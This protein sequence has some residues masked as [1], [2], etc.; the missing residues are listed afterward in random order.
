[1]VD[2]TL[3]FCENNFDGLVIDSVIRVE[4]DVVSPNVFLWLFFR[5]VCM[6]P[7]EVA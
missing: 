6:T 5:K 1:M 4:V 3:S 7:Q 2:F